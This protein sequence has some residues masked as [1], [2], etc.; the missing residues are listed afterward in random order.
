MG[1]GLVARHESAFVEPPLLEYTSP[2]FSANF[3]TLMPSLSS[4]GLSNADTTDANGAQTLLHCRHE[5]GL[6][7]PL[8]SELLGRFIAMTEFF[9]R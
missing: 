7:G 3:T 8:K 1:L 6:L 4:I 2:L 5:F 9:P